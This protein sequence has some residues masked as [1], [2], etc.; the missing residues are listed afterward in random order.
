MKDGKTGGR[1]KR[2]RLKDLK[3]E[4]KKR[5]YHYQSGKK[6]FYIFFIKIE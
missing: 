3:E 2:D 4:F 6:K 1:K 5:F